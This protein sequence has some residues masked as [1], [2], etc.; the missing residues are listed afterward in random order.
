MM[1]IKSFKK[2]L[3]IISLCM[4]PMFACSNSD[5]VQGGEGSNND[6][7]TSEMEI[8]INTALTGDLI[9]EDFSGLS[10]ETGCVRINNAHYNGYF[11]SGDNAQTLQILKIWD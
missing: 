10:V 9:P 1:K 6:D 7:S 8:N 11:F 5:N 4:L 2:L 3:S